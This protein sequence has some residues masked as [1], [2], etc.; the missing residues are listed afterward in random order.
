[1]TDLA[2]KQPRNTLILKSTHQ[3]RGGGVVFLQFPVGGIRLPKGGG[4]LG[5]GEGWEMMGRQ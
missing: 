2:V 3:N 5:V 4:F 1:M